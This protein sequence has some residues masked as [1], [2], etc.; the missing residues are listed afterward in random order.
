[1]RNQ[2]NLKGRTSGVE[3]TAPHSQQM[4]LIG[5]LVCGLWFFVGGGWCVTGRVLQPVSPTSRPSL[6][7]QSDG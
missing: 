1:M 3:L 4:L 5:R 2:Q 6:G 7:G